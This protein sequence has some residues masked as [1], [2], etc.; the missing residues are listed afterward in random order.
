MIL[1]RDTSSK[2]Q[3]DSPAKDSELRQ[4]TEELETQLRLAATSL[5]EFKLRAANAETRLG[6]LSKDTNKLAGLEKEIREKN[7]LIAKLRHDGGCGL[8]SHSLPL[9]SLSQRRICAETAAVV[10]N[11]HLT[12]ALRRLRKNSSD[13]NVDR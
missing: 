5:S 3:A 2:V 10:T 7:Q 4:A 13:T 6:E 9:A 8:D 11:E 12:E 1:S